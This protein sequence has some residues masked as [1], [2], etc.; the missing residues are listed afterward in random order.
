MF[1]I[2]DIYIYIYIDIIYIYIYVWKEE[3]QFKM[4]IQV[5]IEDFFL[6]TGVTFS[7]Y[8]LF[9]SESIQYFYEMGNSHC[10]M[11]FYGELCPHILIIKIS[12]I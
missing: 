12:V 1:D 5:F 4:L 7:P 11:F 6:V 9:S 3:L 8:T 10:Y 2:L